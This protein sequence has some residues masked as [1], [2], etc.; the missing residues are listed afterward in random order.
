[1]MSILHHLP[2][3]NCVNCYMVVEDS[4]ASVDDPVLDHL[5]VLYSSGV[6]VEVGVRGQ[7]SVMVY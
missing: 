1:M 7:S 5:V 3:D 6:L 2:D 4:E